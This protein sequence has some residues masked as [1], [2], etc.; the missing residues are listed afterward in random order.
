MK[1][2]I[3]FILSMA[4]IFSQT[5]F[6][7]RPIDETAEP[8][9]VTSVITVHDNMPGIDNGMYNKAESIYSIV[10]INV[11]ST[12]CTYAEDFEV[13][14]IQGQRANRLY[15]KRVNPDLCETIPQI[16][17]LQLRVEDDLE[18]SQPLKIINPLLIE[19]ITAY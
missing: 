10:E 16:I 14:V 2:L 8:V 9:N 19:S 5:A 11:I 6:A 3:S 15:I 7:S 12:G 18:N 1:I 4:I 13:Y 17:S